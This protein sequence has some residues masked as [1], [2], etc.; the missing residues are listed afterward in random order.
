MT[1][2]R[3]WHLVTFLTVSTALILQTVLVIS[4]SAV[5]DETSVP[6]LATRLFQMFCYFTIQSNLLVAIS[7]AGLVLDPHRDGP[8]WR[9]VQAD[10][11]LGI[12]LTGVVHFIL[13][14]PLLSLT[15][16]PAVA[17]TL[18][19]LVVPALVIS[20]WLLFGPR[21]RLDTRTVWRSLIWPIAW[22]IVTLI[23]GA[24]RDWYPYPFLNVT[25]HG[26]VQVLLTSLAVTGAFL[27]LV[28]A[29]RLAEK[30]LPAAPRAPRSSQSV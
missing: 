7:A 26:Y 23:L 13:L 6:S 16:W 10:A 27:V 9:V 30:L 3:G 28:I 2:A 19:H 22:L 25:E 1:P 8:W 12:T 20:G 14:R 17:D 24:V 29:V 15:G 11:V 21:P 18:L 4:G 5:L